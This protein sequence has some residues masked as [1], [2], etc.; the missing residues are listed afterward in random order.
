MASLSNVHVSQHPSVLA[1]LSQ[2]RSKSASSKDV[3]ALIHEIS[4][5]ISTEALA[6][7]ITPADG[8]KVCRMNMMFY[9]PSS[10]RDSY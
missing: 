10:S 3:K 1:K 8:P 7:A 4:L 2:L 5:V 6:K 9:C